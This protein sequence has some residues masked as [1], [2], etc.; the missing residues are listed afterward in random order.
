MTHSHVQPLPW[1][2]SWLGFPVA[3]FD[4]GPA[5]DAEGVQA[6]IAQCRA[7]G[8]R[9]LY[10]VLNPLAVA[11]AAAARASG[12]WLVDE[13]LTYELALAEAESTLN[14]L[15][16][17]HLARGLAFTPALQ[18]L[19]RS[20]G[21]YSRFR[22]DPRIGLPAFNELYDQWLRRVL[23]QGQVWQATVAGEAA[24]MLAMDG[25]STTATIELLAVAPQARA[26]GL[27]KLLVQAAR[28]EARQRGY[29][30]LQVVTQG[31]NRP[32]RQ[33]YEQGGFRLRHVGHWYHLWL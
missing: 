24:G 17:V 32:G 6:A 10:L 23:A 11:A 18:Q 9:L 26:H 25:S 2:S 7:T 15:P 13:K 19:A 5:D 1:D 3:R 28:W 4:A 12:A 21:E 27:G 29:R 22:H 33:L 31:A 30:T 14:V 20:S 8:I 16:T